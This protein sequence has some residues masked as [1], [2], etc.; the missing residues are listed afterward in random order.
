M[1][2]GAGRYIGDTQPAHVAEHAPEH[3]FLDSD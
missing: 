3:W 2:T 1:T